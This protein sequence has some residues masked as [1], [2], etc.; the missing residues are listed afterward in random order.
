MQ[1]GPIG[2]VYICQLLINLH[3]ESGSVCFNRL[4]V[5]VVQRLIIISRSLDG[6]LGRRRRNM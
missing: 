5:S 2:D 3:L 6:L 4:V 1:S